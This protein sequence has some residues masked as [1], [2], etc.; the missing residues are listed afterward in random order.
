MTGVHGGAKSASKEEAAKSGVYAGLLDVLVAGVALLLADSVVVLADF[1]KTSLEF[2]AVFLSWLAL[3][4][5]ARGGT[6]YEYGLDKLENLSGLVVALLMVFCLISIG[7]GAILN[8]LEPEPVTGVGIYI[9]LA[10]QVVFGVINWRV[11]RQARQQAKASPLAASQARLFLTRLL[12]NAF[13]LVALSLSLSLHGYEWAHYID[14]AAS[15]MI[16][17]SIL[18]AAVGVLR[19]SVFD[20]LDRSL[21]EDEQLRILAALV[22]H[23]H[24]FD[25]LH[26]IR[27]RRAGGRTFIEVFLEFNP[28]LT[29]GVVQAT[30]RDL[31]ARLEQA[32]PGARVTIGL[33]DQRVA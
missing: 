4:R 3:K 10:A 17:V 5:V 20:L 12:G 6:Q 33:A 18:L 2:G 14:P 11:Y 9:C 25:N 16:A 19:N 15:L 26:G 22:K 8:I 23:Y 29:M 21:E 32:V 24:D 28:A 13:V 27:T 30:V 1:M 31:Q 7:A